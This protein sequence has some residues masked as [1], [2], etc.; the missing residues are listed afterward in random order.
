MDFAARE[1]QAQ[2]HIVFY[3]YW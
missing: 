3:Y 2:V 1:L